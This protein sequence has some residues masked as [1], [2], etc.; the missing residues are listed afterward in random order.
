MIFASIIAI[1]CPIQFL[2]P[3]EKGMKICGFC[4]FFYSWLSHLSGLKFRGSLK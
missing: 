2:G 1:C 3:D 4:G